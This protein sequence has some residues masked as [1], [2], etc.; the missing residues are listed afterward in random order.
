ME[1]NKRIVTHLRME[2][3]KRVHELREKTLIEQSEAQARQEA[4]R[5]A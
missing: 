5:R 1:E 4:E 2:E 3:E